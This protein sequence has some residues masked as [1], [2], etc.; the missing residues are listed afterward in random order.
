MLS[1]GVSHSGASVHFVDLEYD[2][3][4]VLLQ[5]RV[6]VLPD[7][8][9]ATLAA[10]VLEQ[11]RACLHSQGPNAFGPEGLHVCVQEHCLYSE[12]IAALVQGKVV[13]KADVPCIV[14]QNDA[15]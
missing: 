13:W 8:T 6:P 3:G 11:V 5:R 10:R 4:P 15:G 7:D 14:H 9:P 2:T 12:A 1:A